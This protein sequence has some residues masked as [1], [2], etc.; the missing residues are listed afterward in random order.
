MKAPPIVSP[1]STLLPTATGYRRRALFD[2]CSLVWAPSMNGELGPPTEEFFGDAYRLDDVEVQ[3]G[4]TTVLSWER[5]ME[6]V[7]AGENP[8]QP[9]TKA[10]MGVLKGLRQPQLKPMLAFL[11]G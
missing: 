2:D 4:G 3:V 5:R 11:A 10:V 1:T 9:G 8:G 6:R 7:L